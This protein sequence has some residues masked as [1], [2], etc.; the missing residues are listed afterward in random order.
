MTQAQQAR[1]TAV[2]SVAS[3][4]AAR[5]AYAGQY[6]TVAR[7]GK[8][9]PED[10]DVP[11]LVYQLEA[12]A[13]RSKLDFQSVKVQSGAPGAAPAA[14]P[15]QAAPDTAKGATPTSP[16]AP[17]PGP[18]PAP[19]ATVTTLPGGLTALPVQL[20]FD[21]SF[22]SLA[23]FLRRVDRFTVARGQRITVHGRL[24]TVDGLSLS[25]GRKGF[26]RV[27]AKLAV[28]AYLAPLAPGVP[29]SGATTTPAP[30]V[31]GA[32]TT[33]ASVGGTG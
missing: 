22:F 18:A 26:P 28:T 29:G 20:I 1:D 8:A 6:A 27:Q 21:G 24:L 33:T 5:D 11:S 31:A 10:E 3:A 23:R 16:S 30:G 15:A 13:R 4:R 7:L 2:A 9:V 17:A 19:G 32:P 14:A 12:V 25:P